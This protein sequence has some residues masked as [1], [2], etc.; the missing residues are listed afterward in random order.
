MKLFLECKNDAFNYHNIWYTFDLKQKKS[1]WFY[2]SIVTWVYLD[3]KFENN[4]R[5]NVLVDYFIST[6]I[7][8]KKV[9]NV[10]TLKGNGPLW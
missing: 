8:S 5:L 1:T 4:I 2:Q 10:K 9:F 3:W 6:R 7:L